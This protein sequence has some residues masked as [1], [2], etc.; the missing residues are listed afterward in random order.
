MLSQYLGVVQTISRTQGKGITNINYRSSGFFSDYDYDYITFENKFNFKMKKFRF[1]TRFYLFGGAGK[2]WA[3]ESMLFLAGSNPEGISDNK[4]TRAEGVFSERNSKI[5]DNINTFHAGGG[6]NLRGYA[7]YLAPEKIGDNQ[8]ATYKGTNGASINIEIEF[9]NYL[10]L[11][12]LFWKKHLTFKTYAFAD[13]GIIDVYEAKENFVFKAPRADAGLGVALTIKKF[14]RLNAVKPF[15]IRAD[16]P[17]FLNRVPNIDPEYI[18]YRWIIGIN[19][20]F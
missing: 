17:V 6:L 12:T 18:N 19:R 2:N 15:T 20:A 4:F 13:A 3:P 1:K 16:F 14:Y 9:D 8:Y 7:G 5:G 10:G 11:N